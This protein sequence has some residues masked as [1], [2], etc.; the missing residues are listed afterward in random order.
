MR[1]IAGCSLL[2][3]LSTSLY[4]QPVIQWSQPFDARKQPEWLGFH[5]GRYYF[6]QLSKDS[7]LQVWAYG[8]DGKQICR[9]AFDPKAFGKSFDYKWTMLN[10]RGPGH[11]FLEDIKKEGLRLSA[12]GTQNDCT[13]L[14]APEPLTKPGEVDFYSPYRTA[15]SPNGDFKIKYRDFIT[16]KGGILHYLIFDKNGNIAAYDSYNFGSLKGLL[17]EAYV[18]NSGRPYLLLRNYRT[19]K[20]REPGQAEQYSVWVKLEKGK[21]PKVYPLDYPNRQLAGIDVLPA[22]GNGFFLA[23]FAYAFEGEP[24]HL[25]PRDVVTSSMDIRTNNKEIVANRLLLFHFNTENGELTSK[26]ETEVSQPLLFDTASQKAEDLIP[27]AIRQVYPAENGGYQIVCEQYQSVRMI[28]G[29][30]TNYYFKFYD[31]AVIETDAGQKPQQVWRF[32]K[33]QMGGA[34]ASVLSTRKNG[35]LY[36][37]Y[38]DLQENLNLLP[39]EKPEWIAGK[40]EKNGLFMATMAGGKLE[41]KEI[42]YPFQPGQPVPQVLL[43]TVTAPGEVMLMAKDRFGLL[44]IE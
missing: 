39:G 26:I 25:I 37:L 4:A 8:P 44:K 29:S 36:L 20:E 40:D 17:Y 21:E 24:K 18:D 10:S 41:R 31:I 28:S 3:Y 6:S 7:G 16:T 30:N 27:Y 43:S 15:I 34:E 14:T 33:R 23:G 13:P 32:P 42:L 5:Q 38:T 12:L 11:H 35:K 9:S 22:P 2:L 1:I 19:K